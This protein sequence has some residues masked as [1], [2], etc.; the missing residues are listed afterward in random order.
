MPATQDF[1]S[2]SAFPNVTAG[3][4]AQG[5]PENEVRQILGGNWLGLYADVWASA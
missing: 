2:V 3:L 1:E 4:L 5:Y